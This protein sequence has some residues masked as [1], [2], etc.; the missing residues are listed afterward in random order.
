MKDAFYFFHDS[1]ARNDPKMLQI[2]VQLGWQGYGLFFAFIEILREQK[3][4]KFPSHAKAT[5]ELSL[6]IDK[7]TL[8]KFFDLAISVGLLVDDGEYIYSESL[9]RR[10][11]RL[12]E[13]RKMLSE[14]GRKGGHAKASSRPPS[15][16][17]KEKKRKEKN[18]YTPKFEQ[19]WK[20][21]PNKQGKHEAARHW[22]KLDF[23]NGLFNK[24]MGALEKYKNST[25]WQREGGKYIPHGSSWVCQKRWD[26][27]IKTTD[28]RS[29]FVL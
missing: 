10:M 12:D 15:S 4:Y 18:I 6:S 23:S 13:K 19:F 3:D 7:A 26:D 24:I 29:K 20:E 9:N 27:E 11:G 5:L 25:E 21:Y 14:A 17:R 1:G 16:K 22:S 2:R 28:N 8:D